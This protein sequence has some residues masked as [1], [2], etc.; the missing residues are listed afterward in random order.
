MMRRQQFPDLGVRISRRAALAVCVSLLSLLVATACRTAHS[1]AG[2]APVAALGEVTIDIVNH[3]WL[4]VVVYVVHDG[5]RDRLGT[6]TA[7]TTTEFRLPIRMLG[8]GRDYRLLGDPIGSRS[9]V[10][11]ETL[12]AEDGEVVTWT[13]ESDLARSTVTFR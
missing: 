10:A 8:A 9:G 5:R 11:T 6:A 13:L 2:Q 3:H 7:T 1:G 12:H 4:D